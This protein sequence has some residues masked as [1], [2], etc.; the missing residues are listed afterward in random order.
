MTSSIVRE[1]AKAVAPSGVVRAIRWRRDLWGDAR[2]RLPADS[3][4]FDGRPG[5]TIG[6]SVNLGSH[7]T[8]WT[9]QHHIV[10]PDFAEVGGPVTAGAYAYL[11]SGCTVLPCARIGEGAVVGAGSVVTRDVPLY[12]LVAGSPARFIRERSGYLDYKLAYAK[13]F[14]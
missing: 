10:A 13:R 7:V 14:V 12:S 9:R 5:L 3:V 1:R 6:S 2:V 11:G 8:S 4:F